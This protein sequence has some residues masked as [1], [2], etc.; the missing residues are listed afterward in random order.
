M[1]A[2][3]VMVDDNFHYMDEAARLRHGAFMTAE[4]AVRACRTL[5]DQWL[6]HNHKPGMTALE[7]YE[8][9]VM[10]GE[11]PYVIAPS[12]AAEVEFSARGYARERAGL[13][14]GPPKAE[15]G[16]RS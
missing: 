7:L 14:C 16:R 6:A 15:Q 5:V 2:Y 4:D 1:S 13:V 9:Y 11:D 3:V 12:G 8:L 10:F